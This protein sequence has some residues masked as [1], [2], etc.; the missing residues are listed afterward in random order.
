MLHS[1]LTA[2]LTAAVVGSSPERPGHE[3]EISSVL[4]K[5]IEQVDVPA[6]EAG[7][8]AAVEIAVLGAGMVVIATLGH[9]GGT[10]V[11]GR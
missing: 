1:V 3:I 9:V 8:L 10:L 11:F 6:K 2:A 4:V 7:V 5:L